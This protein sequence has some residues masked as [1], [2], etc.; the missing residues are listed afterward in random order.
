MNPTTEGTTNSDR[1]LKAPSLPFVTVTTELCPPPPYLNV[2]VADATD[3]SLAIAKKTQRHWA[4]RRTRIIKTTSLSYNPTPILSAS[5]SNSTLP[6]DHANKIISSN[7]SAHGAALLI[8]EPVPE[9]VSEPA[10]HNFLESP[11][12]LTYPYRDWQPLPTC[13]DTPAPHIYFNNLQCKQPSL[14]DL[15]PDYANIRTPYSASQFQ[16][17]LEHA[18]LLKRYP[19]LPFKIAHGF[20]LRKLAPITKTYAPPNLPGVIIHSDTIQAYIAEE[21][22][23]GRFSGPFTHQ[24]LER[25]IGP[26]HSLPLQVAIKEGAPGEPDKFWVCCHLSYK[27][28][29]C[30][31][32]NDEIDADEYPTHWGKATDVMKIV[33]CLLNSFSPLALLSLLSLL[34]TIM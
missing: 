16:F 20:P 4:F 12:A 3:T 25:K 21:L 33:C 11:L 9:F 2:S 32:V 30:S 6:N 14:H 28:E 19:E 5:S 13:N 10:A 27:G 29:L 8:T 23:L 34:Y 7:T 26:F 24:E 15:D 17:F 18:Q 22:C 31:S 1:I